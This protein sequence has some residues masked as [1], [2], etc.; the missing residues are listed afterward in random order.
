VRARLVESRREV[1]NGY[2]VYRNCDGKTA[3]VRRT[4]TPLPWRDHPYDEA[5]AEAFR[6]ANHGDGPTRPM[7][8]WGSGLG[9]GCVDPIAQVIFTDQAS[10]LE[11]GVTA[12]GEWLARENL[13]GEYD[14]IVSPMPVEL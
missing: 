9:T 1:R 12:I 14:I 11:P 5:A 2:E 7:Q 6:Q 8:A 4:G 13:M 10:E 3:V